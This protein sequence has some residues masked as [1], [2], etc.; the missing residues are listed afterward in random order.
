MRTKFFT[1]VALV[2]VVG[3]TADALGAMGIERRSRRVGLRHQRTR[4]CSTRRTSCR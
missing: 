4:P 1:G 3:T 2:A